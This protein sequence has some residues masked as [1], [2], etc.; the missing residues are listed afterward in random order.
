VRFAEAE[1]DQA[2]AAGVVIEF[3]RARPILV[4]RSLY[5]ELCKQA[6]ARTVTELETQLARPRRGAKNTRH[7]AGQDPVAEARREGQRQLRELGID[8]GDPHDPSAPLKW[9]WKFIV[10]RARGYA[11]S[12]RDATVGGRGARFRARHNH[13]DSRKASSLSGGR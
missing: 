11:E 13:S 10:C 8:Y 4:D 12:M 6:I 3:E 2:R 5:R 9:M 1:I 7:A